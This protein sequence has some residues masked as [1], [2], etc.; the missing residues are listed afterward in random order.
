[1]D[2]DEPRKDPEEEYK[3]LKRRIQLGKKLAKDSE[4]VSRVSEFLGINSFDYGSCFL[5]DKKVTVHFIINKLG[6]IRYSWIACFRLGVVL[7]L[8]DTFRYMIKSIEAVD[9]TIDNLE[10]KLLEELHCTVNVSVEQPHVIDKPTLLFMPYPDPVFFENLLRENWS[11]DRLRNL[12][13]IGYSFSTMADF[14]ERN[15]T[16]QK[17]YG[18]EEQCR[19]VGRIQAIRPCVQEISTCREIDGIQYHHFIQEGLGHCSPARISAFRDRVHLIPRPEWAQKDLRFAGCALPYVFSVYFFEMDHETD[20]TSNAPGMAY[21]LT[22][23]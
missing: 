6:R 19:R 21:R 1:M 8:R 11:V 2:T 14:I 12:V 3:R 16:L 20:M 9:P 7:I 10:C 15:I 22:N 18:I 23:V 17:A 5:S 4:L 13:V